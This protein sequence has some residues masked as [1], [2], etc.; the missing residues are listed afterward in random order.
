MSDVLIAPGLDQAI[1]GVVKNLQIVIEDGA[2]RTTNGPTGASGAALTS[3]ATGAASSSVVLKAA[4]GNFFGANCT[5]T[6]SGYL[7]LFDSVAA[8]ADGTVTPKKVWAM[9][10]GSSIEVGYFVP[11]RMAVGVTLVF[12]STGPF[13]K[14]ASATAFMSGEAL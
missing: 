12:S 1:P 2:V 5:A 14:T 3:T 6:V 4:P 11:L 7:M 8:P 13:T 10:A 9:S